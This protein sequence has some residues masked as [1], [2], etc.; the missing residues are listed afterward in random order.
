MGLIRANIIILIFLSIVTLS[1]AIDMSTLIYGEGNNVESFLRS[2]EE[3]EWLYRE[4]M[5][6]QNKSYNTLEEKKRRFEIFKDN[7]L[8]IDEHNNPN[9]NHTFTVG[10]N[11]FA[12]L[13]NEEYQSTYLNTQINMSELLSMPI[14]K[15]YQ[16]NQGDN[17][18]YYVDWRYNG[19]VGPVK[20]QGIC[21]SCWAF[22]AVAT[23]EGLNQIQTGNLITL[24]EQEL[25]DCD[26]GNNGCHRGF[27]HKAYQYMITN[28]GIDSD[29]NYPYIS[30]NGIEGAC[31]WNKAQFASIDRYE[32]GP[33][34]NERAMMKAVAY[35]PISVAVE[36]TSRAFQL[37]TS[38][39]FTQYCGTAID[40]A[41]TI[42][43][44]G[45]EN[46]VDYWIV[47]NSWSSKWGESGYIRMQRN[48]ASRDGKCGIAKYFTYPVKTSFPMKQFQAFEDVNERKS[49]A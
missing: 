29:I 13:T 6:T 2:E 10:L 27:P 9:N 35:Q 21:E 24:S 49:V 15:R 41:V 12:D 28:R 45:T 32:Y 48:V 18:P 34:N 3:M 19:A 4:W 23:V 30:Q 36:S 26:K 38:G 46:Y 8:F 5:L 25:V 11:N 43:G 40:H 44:Y 14:S 39:I 22:S 7:V 17:L 33:L 16:V 37:Y 42:V 1:L 31:K 20:F 47:K